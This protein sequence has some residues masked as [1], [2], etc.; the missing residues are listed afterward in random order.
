MASERE[1]DRRFEKKMRKK[2]L[3]LKR[4]G[5]D[6]ACL[7]RAVAD[8]VYGDEN[9]HNV[10]RR[11]CCDYMA[12]NGD[13]FSQYVTEDWV[14]YVERK[15]RDNC[16]GN[17]V[18]IQAM[19]ELFNRKIEVYVNRSQPINI[20]Q[21]LSSTVNGVDGQMDL[22]MN[23]FPIRLRYH[24][25]IQHYDSLVDPYSAT[26]GVGLG[27]PA[28][29]PGL[30]DRQLMQSALVTSEQES[31]EKQMLE[32]KLRATDWEATNELMEEQAARE[33]YLSWLRENDQRRKHSTG[34]AGHGGRAGGNKSPTS[35][36]NHNSCSGSSGGSA[37]KRRSR[38]NSP[39]AG[40]SMGS[41]N[42]GHYSGEDRTRFGAG[43]K[44]SGSGS[45]SSPGREHAEHSQGRKKQHKVHF[46]DNLQQRLSPPPT[47]RGLASPS[48]Q[49]QFSEDEGIILARVLAESRQE[50]LDSLR[51]ARFNGNQSGGPSREEKE[52]EFEEEDYNHASGSGSNRN[53]SDFGQGPRPNKRRK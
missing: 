39:E 45:R 5:E 17:H 7:F 6:G 35:A 1:E 2:G 15:R 28:F 26:I 18:E 14:H 31:L 46:Q 53:F 25:R 29:T 8:Q 16:Y 23:E 13:Y 30:A 40:A 4:M 11:L 9:E 43:H 32:D 12:K 51:Q 20:F 49:Q 37:N 44:S 34:S 38:S 22:E 33:S 47:R 52:E 10:V 21:G 48:H 19:S 41:G 24:S 36:V 42:G 3:V 27:L 50:Y